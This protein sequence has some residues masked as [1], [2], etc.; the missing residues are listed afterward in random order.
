MTEREPQPVVEIET[1]LGTIFVAL[2]PAAAPIT[3]TNFLRYVDSG[4][5]DGGVFHRTVT[6]ANQ[7]DSPVLIEVIQGGLGPDRQN[8]ANEPIPLERT[9][10]TG[11]RHVDG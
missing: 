1:S 7:P 5:Y 10:V 2:A 6:L 4:S 8:L 11:L 3:C 9:S